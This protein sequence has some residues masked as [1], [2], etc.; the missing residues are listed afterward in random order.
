MAPDTIPRLSLIVRVWA[1][2]GTLESYYQT[3]EGVVWRC[4]PMNQYHDTSA[5]VSPRIGRVVN[6]HIIG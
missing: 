1:G 5:T 3:M 4:D 2:P 6:G